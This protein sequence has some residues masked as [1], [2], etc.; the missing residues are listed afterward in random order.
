MS[1]LSST[2]TSIADAIRA[3][4]GLATKYTPA[5]MAA[6]IQ[7][8]TTSQL[9]VNKVGTGDYFKGFYADSACTTAYDINKWDG[10]TKVYAKFIELGELKTATFAEATEAELNSIFSLAKAGTI[11][12]ASDIGWAVG[13]TRTISVSA[14]TAGGNVEVAKQDIDLVIS[15]FDDYNGAGAKMQ[16]DFKDCITPGVRMNSSDTN[17]GGW[18]SSEMYTTTIPALLNALP[19]WLKNNLLEFTTKTSEGN[20]SSEIEETTGNKLALRSE[21]EIFGSTTYSK[22]GE[23][24]QIAYY[25]TSGNRVKKLGHSG[26]AS[27]WWLRSPYGGSSTSFCGVSSGGSADWYGAT[28][29]C[30]VAPFGCI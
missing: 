28:D 10:T 24:S 19:T 22:S 26:S 20:R 9:P 25:K 3:K 18:P 13:D 12:I 4:N 23:G 30:G 8:L 21:I 1:T 29:T 14:F 2:F 11:D 16:I 7:A 6:A 5:G 27:R 17:S 15:S